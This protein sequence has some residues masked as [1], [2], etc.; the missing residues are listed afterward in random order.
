[1]KLKTLY[2]KIAHRV[3]TSL[4][5]HARLKELNKNAEYLGNNLAE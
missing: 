1:M 4:S 5:D 3:C 2:F